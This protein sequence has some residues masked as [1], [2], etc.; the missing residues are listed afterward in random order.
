[1]SI[2]NENLVADEWIAIALCTLPTDKKAVAEAV[3]PLYTAEKLE[4]P[5]VIIHFG[6]PKALLIARALLVDPASALGLRP[7]QLSD[8]V[9][10]SVVE[11]ALAGL[12]ELSAHD[13]NIGDA[14]VSDDNV[15]ELKR[16]VSDLVYRCCEG[17]NESWLS[18][19]DYLRRF[20]NEDVSELNGLFG[21]AKACGWNLPMID[22]FFAAE[23]PCQLHVNERGY[24]HSADGP[25]IAWPDGSRQFY[26]DGLF[27]PGQLVENPN[28]YT[29][30]DVS[31]ARN[32]EYVRV[33]AERIGWEAFMNL[34]E[35]TCDDA[36]TDPVTGLLYELFSLP[37]V[38]DIESPKLL[39]KQSPALNDEAQPSYVERVD[40]RI[41]TAQAARKLQVA[42]AMR[43]IT[44]MSVEETIDYCNKNP[45]LNYIQET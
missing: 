40:N 41:L 3:E 2:E 29:K 33:L 43:G 11:S 37:T 9:L 44:N 4:R 12:R 42:M 30:A 28:A 39:R 26:W 21:L 45:E 20:E 25:A 38:A 23:R 19:Y 7:E 10:P 15:A 14:P 35:A 16:K 13:P 36:W 31:K 5:K 32:T 34:M 6:S 24:L 8:Y 27:I 22:C 1:M 17:Q 18:G